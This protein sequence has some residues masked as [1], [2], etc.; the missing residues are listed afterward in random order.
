[1]SA[2]SVVATAPPGPR[3]SKDSLK[4]W[5]AAD[6]RFV[7]TAVRTNPALSGAK[8]DTVMSTG[9]VESALVTYFRVESRRPFRSQAAATRRMP[10]RFKGAGARGRWGVGRRTAGP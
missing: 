5:D 3:K 8:L 4:G 6:R 1:M 7:A 2:G 9:R 10:V